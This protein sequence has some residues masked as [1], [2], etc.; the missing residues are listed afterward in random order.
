MGNSL[1]KFKDWRQSGHS[2][3]SLPQ[4]Y[5]QF[6]SKRCPHSVTQ[7][8]VRS[9]KQSVHVL[10]ALTDAGTDSKSMTVGC[11]SLSVDTRSASG[12][13]LSKVETGRSSSCG[14]SRLSYSGLFSSE[15]DG[16]LRDGRE[17]RYDR[18]RWPNRTRMSTPSNEYDGGRVFGSIGVADV[19][20][21]P[22]SLCTRR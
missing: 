3:L 20:G 12:S 8:A 16:T 18:R 9:S 10:P 1:V 15:M 14:P 7:V 13:Y 4:L 5:I 19:C 22:R 21:T 6:Q 17:R 11:S 2:A